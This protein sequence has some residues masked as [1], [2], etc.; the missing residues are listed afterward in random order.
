MSALVFERLLYTDCRPGEGLG[1]GGGYQIQAQSEGMSKAQSD[2]AVEWLLYAAQLRW[3]NEGRAVADFPLGF[4]H[5]ADAGFGTAQSKYLGKEV[6]GSRQGNYVA[7]CLLTGAPEPYGVIRPAQ[8]WLAPFWRQEI[9]PSTTAPVFDEELEIG[10]LDH[11]AI[12]GWLRSSPRRAAGLGRLLTVLEDTSGPRVVIRADEPEAALYWIAAATILLPMTDALAVSFRVFASNIDDSPHRVVAVPRDLHP[13]L[14]PGARARTFIID[15]GTDETDDLKVSARASFW[16]RQLVEAE[17]PYDVVEAVE[18]AAEIGGRDDRELSDARFAAMA[19]CDPD[20]P[21]GDVAGVGRWL[22]RAL[23]TKHDGAAQSI[24]T[25]LIGAEDVR[26]DD[27]RL[28]DQLAAD[29]IVA[30]DAGELRTRLLHAE[31]GLAA[32]GTGS[33]LEQLPVVRL[34]AARRSDNKSAVVSAMLIGS[35]QVLELLLCLAWRHGLNLDPPAPALVDRLRTFV[36]HLLHAPQVKVRLGN[37]AL[38]HLITDEI[39]GQLRDVFGSGDERALQAMLPAVVDHLAV[40][41]NDYADSF[42]WEIEGCYTRTLTPDKRVARIQF[43][44]EQLSWAAP[45]FVDGYQA[46]LVRWDAVDPVTA[47]QVVHMIPARF[48]LNETILQNATRELLARAEYPDEAIIGPIES[49]DR[50]GALPDHPRLK[51]ILRSAAAI[52]AFLSK[53]ERLQPGSDL[54][55]LDAELRGLWEADDDVIALSIRAFA[56]VAHRDPSGDLGLLILRFLQDRPSLWFAR[57]WGHHVSAARNE[58]RAV[59]AAFAWSINKAVA[60]EARRELAAQVE[61]VYR[62]LGDDREPWRAAVSRCLRTEEERLLFAQFLDG[63]LGGRR[64]GSWLFGRNQT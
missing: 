64:R 32:A 12:A 15:A 34:A 8:L 57:E 7:D 4:A 62:S 28:L 24:I 1:S 41:G 60:Q 48:P 10:P 25:R 58:L 42:T 55:V 50:R 45:P 11:D 39:H 33:P 19:V 23:G 52:D 2:M 51:R 27:L 36:T 43:A 22:R 38:H 46:S 20:R 49:L 30:V 5:T 47:L 17:E 21:I 31:I 35:D 6:N 53:L 61:A 16:V 3:V 29:G 26:I 56:D 18:L 59:A 44:I 13:N 63:E 14:V 9:W 40:R 37:W 54:G